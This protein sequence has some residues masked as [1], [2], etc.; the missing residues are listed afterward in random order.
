MPSPSINGA[1]RPLAPDPEFDLAKAWADSRHSPAHV[2]RVWRA[3]YKAYGVAR[4]Q[5]S[6]VD[7]ISLIAI[8]DVIAMARANRRRV[9]ISYLAEETGWPRTTTLRDEIGELWAPC[10]INSEWAPLQTVLLHRPGP[11]L[12]AAAGDPDAAHMLAPLD[13]DT[14]GAEHEIGRAHV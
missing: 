8:L 10:G 5:F 2:Y 12:V 7:W 14:A 6:D 11:E 1:Q 13:L 9:D 4:R 3:L